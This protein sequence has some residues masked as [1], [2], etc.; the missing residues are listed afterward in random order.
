MARDIAEAFT[1]V[2]ERMLTRFGRDELEKLGFEIDR[3]LRD[4]RAEQPALDDLAA[5]QARNRRLQ[6][7]HQ[8]QVVLRAY[9]LKAKT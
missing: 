9:R 1:L 7:L 5:I 6:R 2:T 3:L 8:A 4:L